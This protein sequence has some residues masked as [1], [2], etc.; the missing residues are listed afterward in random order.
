LLMSP[1]ILFY[2]SPGNDQTLLG[3]EARVPGLPKHR[4]VHQAFSTPPSPTIKP[5]R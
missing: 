2:L 4:G 5:K 1:G 3:A